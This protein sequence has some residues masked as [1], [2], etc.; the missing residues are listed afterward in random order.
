MNPAIQVSE[1]T[2]AYQ[3]VSALE[4]VN[5]IIPQGSRCAIVGPN[6]AGKS[7]LFKSLLG[8]EKARSGQIKLLGQSDHLS[9][10]IATRVAYIPQASQVNWQYPA[11]VYDIVLMGRYPHIKNWLKRPTA[12]DKEIVFASLEKMNLLDLKNRQISELS[13]GQRQ[14]VFIARALAQEAELYL[15]DEP[16]AGIDIKTEEIIMSILREFQEEGKTSVVIHHDLN[17]IENYFDYLVWLNKTVVASGELAEVLTFENYQKAYQSSAQ[18][19][20]K[21]K[22][23]GGWR[24]A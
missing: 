12:K 13:G 7:T 19:L 22:E 18:L 9:Q 24:H 6:G 23:Q 1:L 8:F 21:E 16:L 11:T 15:M 5:L 2:V 17:T 14:R 20:F 10:M 4:N 3:Q